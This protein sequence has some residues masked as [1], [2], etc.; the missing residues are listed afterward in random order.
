MTPASDCSPNSSNAKSPVY[1]SIFGR[2]KLRLITGLYCMFLLWRD[3]YVWPC[4]GFLL[5]TCMFWK[6]FC[7]SLYFAC[8]RLFAPK[9]RGTL[10]PSSAIHHHHHLC[11]RTLLMRERGGNMRSRRRGGKGVRRLPHQI[12][13]PLPH[14]ALA[15]FPGSC[16]ANLTL[17]LAPRGNRSTTTI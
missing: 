11:R 7:V 1:C 15:Q 10:L 2:D 13:P 4:P 5:S 8:R 6:P 17:L 9:G 16:L 3:W 14:H 12:Y